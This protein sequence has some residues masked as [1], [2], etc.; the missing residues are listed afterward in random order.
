MTA[1]TEYRIRQKIVRATHIVADQGL[2]RSSDGNISVRLDDERLLVTPSGI[3]KMA[4][5]P[6]DPVVVNYDG[7]TLSAKEGL[8]PTSELG[9]HLE[10]YRQRPDVRAVIHAHPP[11]ATALTIAGISFPTDYVPEVLVGLGAV[12]TA[13]YA[14]PGTPALGESI[15]EL[16]KTNNSVLLSNHGALT[17]G[18]TIEEALITMERLEHAA[19][20]YYIAKMLGEPKALPKDELDKLH[21]VG[22]K[23]NLLRKQYH[24]LMACQK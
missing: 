19:Y 10:V 12:P 7:E 21:E 3:Y 16:I 17:V 15:R 20:T 4:M 6:D 11:Y 14:T 2:V 18:E 24:N 8:K 1:L 22:E 9:M 23:I 5:E 13:E